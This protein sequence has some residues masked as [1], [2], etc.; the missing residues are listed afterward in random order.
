MKYKIALAQIAPVLGKIEDNLEKHEFYLR[1]AREEKVD[2]VVFP[3]LSLTGYELMDLVPDVALTLESPQIKEL[4]KLS[5]ISSFFSGFVLEEKGIFYNVAAL[6]HKGE[7]IHL[8]KKVFLPN[9]SMF[10]EKRFF[11]EGNTFKSFELEGTRFAISICYDYLH[12]SSSYVYFLQK[13]E[14]LVVMSASPARVLNNQGF[15]SIKG[16]EDMSSVVSRFFNMYV[17]YVNRAGF[18]GG[19]GFAGASHLFDP[20]G[21]MIVKLKE[22]EED[23]ATAEID[24]EEVRRSRILFPALRDERTEIIFKEIKK[25]LENEN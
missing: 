14:I 8:H 11:A 2:L 12:P 19:M 9:Y 22:F 20:F 16:W 24:T 15:W 7:I 23:Y 6:F 5:K 25:V 1:K 13:T 10:E 3:E 18:E 4:K 21:N 17:I